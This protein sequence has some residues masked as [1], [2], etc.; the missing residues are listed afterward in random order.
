MSN[1]DIPAP[2][3]HVPENAPSEQAE[4]TPPEQVNV[5]SAYVGP[6]MTK[7]EVDN[8][9]TALHPALDVEARGH[10]LY[11]P[12]Y[13]SVHNNTRWCGN[14]VCYRP[15]S[16][17]AKCATC[18]TLFC[19]KACRDQLHSG[20]GREKIAD[21]PPTWCGKVDQT[22]AVRNYLSNLFLMPENPSKLDVFK[23]HQIVQTLEEWIMLALCHGE[24]Y[25]TLSSLPK[26]KLAGA[27]KETPAYRFIDAMGLTIFREGPAPPDSKMGD[28]TLVFKCGAENV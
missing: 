18:K 7:E 17:D 8:L 20:K 11:A 9:Y 24:D 25:R 16:T 28:K 26:E 2:P 22:I 6:D 3:E 27:L 19:G 21:R 23:E 15:V 4:S 14:P 5:R 1:V 12:L 10:R 13:V